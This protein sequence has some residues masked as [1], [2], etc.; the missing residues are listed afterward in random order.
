MYAIQ[1]ASSLGIHCV[2]LVNDWNRKEFAEHQV[3]IIPDF[4]SLIEK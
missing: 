1:T 3:D 4:R 2:G